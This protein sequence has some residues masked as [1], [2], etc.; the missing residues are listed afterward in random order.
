MPTHATEHDRESRV[1]RALPRE[2]GPAPAGA[3]RRCPSSRPRPGR[4]DRLPVSPTVTLRASVVVQFASRLARK[5]TTVSC[6]S[7]LRGTTPDIQYTP[8]I[9]P[10][11]P[12]GLDLD[13]RRSQL[14]GVRLGPVARHLVLLLRTS[15]GGRPASVAAFAG[16]ASGFCASAR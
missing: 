9:S 2:V 14:L 8:W 4:A 1:R 6:I 11:N 5:A 10:S 7:R 12:D 16:A 15:A 3:S 13:T